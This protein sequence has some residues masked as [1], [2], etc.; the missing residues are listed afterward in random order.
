MFVRFSLQSKREVACYKYGI[1][2]DRSICERLPR[3]PIYNKLYWV[4]STMGQTGGEER[5]ILKNGIYINSICIMGSDEG[6]EVLSPFA[7]P[8]LHSKTT[9]ESGGILYVDV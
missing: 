9:V 5:V 6:M 1:L 8:I 4:L 3:K 2:K 7:V